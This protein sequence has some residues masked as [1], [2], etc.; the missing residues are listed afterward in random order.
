MQKTFPQNLAFIH[1][2]CPGTSVNHFSGMTM[3]LYAMPV[4]LC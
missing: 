2:L 1:K 4:K 3:E